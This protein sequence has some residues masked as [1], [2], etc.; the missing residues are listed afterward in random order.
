MPWTCPDCGRRNLADHHKTCTVEGCAGK[1]AAWTLKAGKTREFVVTRKKKV[2]FLRLL[3]GR[4]PLPKSVVVPPHVEDY[5]SSETSVA[6][7]AVAVPASQA[8]A[9]IEGGLLPPPEVLLVARFTGYTTG[10]RYLE[11]YAKVRY[12]TRLEDETTPQKARDNAIPFPSK[13]ARG[14]KQFA[15]LYHLFVYGEG[16]ERVNFPD[17]ERIKV[18]DVSEEPGGAL[19]YARTV[20][21]LAEHPHKTTKTFT[22]D[23]LEEGFCR[24]LSCR[25]LEFLHDSYLMLP[26]GTGVLAEVLLQS[27]RDPEL[28][29]VV[30]GHADLSGNASDNLT[31]S[32]NR[33]KTILYLLDPNP[34]AR[35]DWVEHC[36]ADWEALKLPKRAKFREEIANWHEGRRFVDADWSSA[37]SWRALGEVFDEEVAGY[38][39]L[40]PEAG[41]VSGGPALMTEAKQRVADAWLDPD[42]KTVPCGDRYTRIEGTV[43]GSYQIR[44]NR[45]N[46]FLWFE[47]DRGPWVTTPASAEDAARAIYGEPQPK[48]GA[49]EVAGDFEYDRDDGPFVFDELECPPTSV[50]AAPPGRVV[51]VADFS[52][53][54]NSVDEGQTKSRLKHCRE[55]LEGLLLGGLTKNEEFALVIFGERVQTWG[56]GFVTNEAPT[57]EQAVE[58]LGTRQITSVGGGSTNLYAALSA[59]YAL[60]GDSILLL[61]DGIPTEGRMSEHWILSEGLPALESPF[62]SQRIDTCGFFVASAA[63][64]VKGQA[65]VEDYLTR[66]EGLSGPLDYFGPGGKADLI[67]AAASE[68]GIELEIRE[69]RSEGGHEVPDIRPVEPYLLGR[70]LSDLCARS[71]EGKPLPEQGRFTNL[72]SLLRD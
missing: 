63:E 62:G 52:S 53:S 68:N 2:R 69:G 12:D 50:L 39:G 55:Q 70:F 56:S 3:E 6:E 34:A 20:Q 22:L 19:P 42:W 15:D 41:G 9:W 58:W 1:K 46:E 57:R 47:A 24:R 14:K 8:L 11:C 25:Q 32:E 61:S 65:F 59:A 36:L 17:F 51:I 48:R 21:L 16:V 29:L 30:T 38:L 4:E 7:A 23:A 49:P 40:S 43:D 60:R 71:T 5:C 33:G 18:V 67:S 28:K 64:S 35:G 13:A 66:L 54:M 10:W 31:L 37:V 44:T 72:Y 45:R 27:Y 26:H